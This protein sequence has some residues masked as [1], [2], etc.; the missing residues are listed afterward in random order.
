[1]PAMGGAVLAA[2]SP[3]AAARATEIQSADSGVNII[4]D[5]QF[6]RVGRMQMELTAARAGLRPRARG[7]AAVGLGLRP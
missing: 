3:L 5:A 4:S 7:H 1:M 6:K 2:C